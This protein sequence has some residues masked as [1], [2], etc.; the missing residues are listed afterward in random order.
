MSPVLIFIILLS[1]ERSI[2]SGEG[3]I[4]FLAIAFFIA[5]PLFSLALFLAWI[6]LGE[7]IIEALKL[8]KKAILIVSKGIEYIKKPRSANA[9]KGNTKA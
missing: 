1:V 5:F 6:F 2:D 3:L 8:L 4:F 7:T 9:K